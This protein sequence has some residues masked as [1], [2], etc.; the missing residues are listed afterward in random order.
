MHE[1]AANML[2]VSSVNIFFH[3]LG[4]SALKSCWLETLFILK[5][6]LTK[7]SCYSAVL[8]LAFRLLLLTR[9]LVWEISAQFLPIQ[10]QTFPELN[11]SCNSVTYTLP[12]V[13]PLCTW[14]LIHV[15]TSLQAVSLQVYTTHILTSHCWPLEATCFT[16]TLL[17]LTNQ[18][19]LL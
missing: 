12:R 19:V 4:G 8:L 14:C 1:L 9:L 6:T 13:T 5:T 2:L 18:I 10:I 15:P 11:K 17:L 16:M 3:V 7:Q